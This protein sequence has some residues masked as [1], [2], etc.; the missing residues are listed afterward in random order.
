MSDEQAIG[1]VIDEMYAMISGPAGPEIIAYISSITA[2]IAA[3]SLM[4]ERLNA[5]P[6]RASGSPRRASNA[7]VA[8]PPSMLAWPP[9]SPVPPGGSGNARL[10]TPNPPLKSPGK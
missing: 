8:Q 6:P 3:S 2:P 4:A 10:G 1:A 7:A 9:A 5:S